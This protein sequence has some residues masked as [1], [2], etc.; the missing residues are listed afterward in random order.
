MSFHLYPCL[1]THICESVTLNKGGIVFEERI[2]IVNQLTVKE[3]GYP[4][5]FACTQWNHKGP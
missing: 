3:G 2:E 1:S 4:G 5:L